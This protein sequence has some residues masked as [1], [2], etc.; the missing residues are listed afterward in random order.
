M[1]T[2]EG[3]YRKCL[4]AAIQTIVHVPSRLYEGHAGQ[5]NVKG[6][7]KWFAWLYPV[8][9]AIYPAGFCTLREVGQAMINAA[10]TGYPHQILEVKDIVQL[11]Q[12]RR[13]C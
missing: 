5:R 1:G 7:Y 6:Y 2:C 4:D 8:G 10:T 9:R 12:A 11:A 13:E 3:R